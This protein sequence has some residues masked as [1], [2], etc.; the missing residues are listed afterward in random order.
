MV[1]QNTKISILLPTR[2]RTKQLQASI[3]SLLNNADAPGT[4]QWILGWDNDDTDSFD[5]FQ[6]NIQPLIEG[7][8]GK[9]KC[10]GFEPLGYERLHV[11]VNS[12]AAQADGKW[13]VFWNDDAIMESQGWDTEILSHT[14]KFCLQAFETHNGHPYSIFPIVPRE[15][16]DQVGH[17]SLHQL[18]DAWLSQIAWLL[19]IVVRIPI[20]VKHDRYDLTGNNRD[21]TFQQRRIF[22]GKPSDPRDFNH[23]NNRHKRLQEAEYL[24]Q[25][26]NFIGQK[27]SHWEDIKAGRIDGWDKMMAADY[28]NHLGK[29]PLSVK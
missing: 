25:Y 19:D 3:E 24:S 7:S 14:G 27:S 13:F 16:Y 17:L 5:Y 26:L 15:W 11:Y 10:L 29:W 23:V 21:L 28:N 9:Y 2:G 4:L 18:N 20:N 8:G 1:D 6:K 22:E 12:L